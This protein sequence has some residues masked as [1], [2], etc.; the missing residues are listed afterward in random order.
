MNRGRGNA[1]PDASRRPKALFAVLVMLAV[2]V[3]GTLTVGAAM[4]VSRG[5]QAVWEGAPYPKADPDAVARRLKERSQLTYDA[6][7]L[8]GAHTVQ[9]ARMSDGACYYRGL[10]SLGHID[11][12]RRDVRSFGLSWSVED[13][14]EEQARASQDR[15]RQQL[16][17]RGWELTRDWNRESSGSLTLGSTFRHPG[18]PDQI[19]VKWN[20]STTTLFVDVYAEC[21]RV[22]A[23]YDSTAEWT[24]AWVPSGPA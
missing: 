5:A 20:D 3:G 13:V 1:A 9:P 23:G 2:A 17:E 11:E 18:T 10:E 21:G 6:F 8:P 4:A 15:L 14:P 12:A 22:P 16:A 24:A 7:G 19:H